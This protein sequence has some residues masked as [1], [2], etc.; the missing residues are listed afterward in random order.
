MDSF[1]FLMLKKL[2]VHSC[3][4]FNVYSFKYE[5]FVDKK[6]DGPSCIFVNFTVAHNHDNYKVSSSK[7]KYTE[8]IE[9]NSSIYD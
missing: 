5:K 7:T 3:S 6:L 9:P 2:S 4:N 1:A 8:L